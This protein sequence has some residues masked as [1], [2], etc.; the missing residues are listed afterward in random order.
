MNSLRLLFSDDY[1]PWEDL[2]DQLNSFPVSL[3]YKQMKSQTLTLAECGVLD[4]ADG[5]N[6]VI[7]IPVQE[8]Q[9][10]L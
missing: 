2:Q 7:V 4:P 1:P 5:I 3:F 6:A 9:L 10:H 8:A